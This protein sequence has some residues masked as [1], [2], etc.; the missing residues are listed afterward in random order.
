MQQPARHNT[1]SP[2]TLTGDPGLIDDS[3]F[4]SPPEDP[5]K[6]LKKWLETASQLNVREPSGLTLAT[7]DLAG[8]PS[9]RVVLL[10]SIDEKGI[11]FST[12]E[13]S[14][15]GQNLKTNPLAAGSLWWR[16]TVQQVN[17]QGHVSKLS[18]EISDAIFKERTRDA[19]AIA[20]ISKQSAPLTDEKALRDEMD[21]LISAKG[22]IT[23]PKAWHAYILEP[24]NIE[25]WHGSVD[26]FH[27]RLRY[28]FIFHGP[29]INLR[30]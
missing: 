4:S 28:D 8:H 16:E 21:R 29:G 13:E 23:R 9:T 24:L 12:S 11:I 7:V 5:L 6:L 19:K 30:L 22:E 20:V 14:T 27:K 2:E 10:K 17:F 26:R 1:K 25:F 18:E 3:D 15:K